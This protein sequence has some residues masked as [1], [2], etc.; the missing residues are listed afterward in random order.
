MRYFFGTLSGLLR[1]L[2][3]V[4]PHAKRHVSFKTTTSPAVFD[5]LD[6]MRLPKWATLYTGRK[7]KL[8]KEPNV[9]HAIPHTPC[10]LE[11]FSDRIRVTAAP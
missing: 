9:V 1:T 2:F 6:M 10:D 8:D 11:L 7:R 4:T 3:L 5:R